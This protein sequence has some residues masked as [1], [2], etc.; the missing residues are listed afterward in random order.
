MGWVYILRGN[1]NRYYVGSTKDVERRLS[2]HNNGESKY[3]KNLRPLKLV[4][5]Q[6]FENL[7]QA[8]HIEYKL[9]KLKRR[10]YL[11]K[12]IDSGKISMDL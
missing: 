4:F 7:N 1:N 12:I 3:T 2:Q 10:D 9:K 11:D 5:Q 8:R 6:R